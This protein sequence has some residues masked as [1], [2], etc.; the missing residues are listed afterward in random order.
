MSRFQRLVIVAVVA[1]LAVAG[2]VFAALRA[3][4]ADRPGHAEVVAAIKNDPRTADVP[5]PAASCVATWY[6]DQ[7]GDDQ[8]QALLGG[9]TTSAPQAAV[10]PEASAAILDCLKEAT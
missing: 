7:A 8:L 4:G 2:G 3:T 10:S 6:L 1:A 5:D 9:D